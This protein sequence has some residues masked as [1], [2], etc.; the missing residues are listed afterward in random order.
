MLTY[1]GGQIIRTIN[2]ICLNFSPFPPPPS[3]SVVACAPLYTL[4]FPKNV[5]SS[6]HC[7]EGGGEGQSRYPSG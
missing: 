7:L 3:S 2:T 4:P 6:Q 1:N 5:S